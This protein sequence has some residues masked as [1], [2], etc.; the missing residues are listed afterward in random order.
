MYKCLLCW[1]YLRTRYLALACIVSV[2]LGVATLIVVNSVMAGFSTKL[3]ERLHQLLSD[4]VI[5]AEGMEGFEDP[6]G[7]MAQI[8]SDPFL[9]PRI[10]AMSPTMEVF[11][12]LQYHAVNN[13]T[14]TRP[15][16]VIG[17]EPKTREGIGGFQEHL[18]YQKDAKNPGFEVSP[19]T[20]EMVIRHEKLHFDMLREWEL[21]QWEQQK[22]QPGNE[23]LPPPPA[24]PFMPKV[25]HPAVPGF[26]IANF[27]FKD[28]ETGEAREVT[29]LPPG[30]AI[31]LMTI[32]GQKLVPVYDRFIVTDHFRSE[33]SEYDGN[34]IF[35]ELSYL[36]HLRTMQ[37]R[38]TSIQIR[39]KDYDRDAPEVVRAMQKL[40]R[41]EPIRITTWE[42]KQG[43]LLQ[44]IRIEK[45]ILNVLL[46]LI[47]AV[48]GFG[49][50]AIF[51]MIVSEKTRDIGILKALG[52]PSGGVMQIFLGYGLLLG[53]VGSLLG[54]G[55]GLWLTNN[56]N[57]VE[58]WLAG[59]TGHHLFDPTV[60][61]FLEIPTDVQPS[62]VLI[63]NLGA[64]AV[65]VVFSILPA[66]R[67]ARLH[68]VQAL[69]YE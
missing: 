33:M 65:A 2:M 18:V 19:E 5:E 9:G 54:T 59:Q 50:L 31:T 58:R 22:Q 26:L 49:I 52:A 64:I 3:R 24:T 17:I 51:S 11:A 63:V 44:A 46:F 29:T 15:V 69:R 43:P 28:P 68:P 56:I 62:A 38:V 25:P 30:S 55:A 12:L 66:I 32:S 14:I 6:Y 40:F 39:L 21:K 27:R 45:G 57:E 7:K 47:V 37:D 4:V 34:Y 23:N 35:V 36:Q 1:R 16:R 61:Y 8:K 67:A 13:R 42:D 41:G 20:R 53:L 60:Y 10:A 48:A